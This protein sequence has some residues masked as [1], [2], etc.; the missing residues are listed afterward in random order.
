MNRDRFPYGRV[1]E[2]ELYKV[3]FDLEG[4]VVWDSTN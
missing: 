4:E 3:E 1:I 2:G